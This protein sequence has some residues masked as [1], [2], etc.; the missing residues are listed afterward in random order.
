MAWIPSIR[1]VLWYFHE[2]VES[3]V[4]NTLKLEEL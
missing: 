1:R 2:V 3:L 4:A